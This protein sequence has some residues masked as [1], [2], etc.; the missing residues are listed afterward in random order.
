M[1]PGYVHTSKRES[2]TVAQLKAIIEEKSRLLAMANQ[3]SADAQGKLQLVEERIRNLAKANSVLV[4]E[5]KS[6]RARIEELEARRKDLEGD[7]S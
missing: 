6:L 5:A 1:T 3:A 2:R 7:R 4:I